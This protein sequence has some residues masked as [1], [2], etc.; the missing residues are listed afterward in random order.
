MKKFEVKKMGIASVFKCNFY[1]MLIPSAVF[2]LVGIITVLIG[3]V[4]QE[5]EF[6]LLGVLA[7]MLYPVLL[8]GFSG[9][10]YML[11]GLIYNFFAQR[12]GGL[13]LTL[14]EKELSMPMPPEKAEENLLAET[15]ECS[16]EDL[17]NNVENN[18]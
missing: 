5:G 12:F 18:E 4:L 10:M 3:I 9:L 14:E 7:G 16:E 15:Q 13:E 11:M 1:M 17:E 8:L 2:L 6:I